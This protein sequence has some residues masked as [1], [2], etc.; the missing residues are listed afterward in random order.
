MTDPAETSSPALELR[1]GTPGLPPGPSN[2]VIN[3]ILAHRSYR[4]FLDRSLEPGALET[5]VAAASSA[6]SSSNM[7]TWSV[8]A[9]EDPGRKDRLATLAGN[10]GFIRQAPL[11]LCWIADLSRLERMGEAHQQ[12]LAGL[13]YLE[14]FMV[15]LVDA[16][17]ASQNALVAA[18]S[19]GLGGVYVGGLRNRP[20]EVAAEL[21]LPPKAFGAFG[22][23]IGWPDPAARAEVKPR[24][25]QS[26]VLHRETYGMAGE[27]AAVAGY[28]EVLAGFSEENGMGRA[29]WTGRMLKRVAGP[30]SLSGRH[31][32][33][34]TLRAMGFPLK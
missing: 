27:D 19:I 29:D 23:A 5:I 12:R 31:T 16:A 3:A 30:E 7:Q 24:L 21:N 34:E 13:D 4:H 10:Q 22:M 26:L 8:V 1:Y 18:E 9:V 25:P 32:M 20:K 33:T 11:F 17:L 14:S 2:P 6:P 28:D 15:A